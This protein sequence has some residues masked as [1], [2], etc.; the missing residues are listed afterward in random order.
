LLALQVIDGLE[1]DE[2]ST[3]KKPSQKRNNKIKISH[4]LESLQSTN[5]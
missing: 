1:G 2:K 4:S 3:I 5:H